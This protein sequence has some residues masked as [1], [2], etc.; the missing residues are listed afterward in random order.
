MDEALEGA[1]VFGAVEQHVGAVDVRGGEL[2]AVAETEIDVGLRG[3]VE[4]GVNGVGPEDGLH[5]GR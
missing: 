1:A 4:D 3:E 5:A 2:V